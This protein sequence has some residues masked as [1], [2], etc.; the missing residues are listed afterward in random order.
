MRKISIMQPFFFPSLYYFFLIKNADIFV[1]LDNVQFSKQSWQS[2]NRV[3]INHTMNWINLPLE[4]SKSKKNINEIYIN[5][6]QIF[7]IKKFAKKINQ[8]CGLSL[9]GMDNFEYI[10]TSLEKVGWNLS[11]FNILNIENICNLFEIDT[12]F[13][14]SSELILKDTRSERLLDIVKQMGGDVYNATEGAREYMELDGYHL[15]DLNNIQINY[16]KPNKLKF[17]PSEGYASAL[18]YLSRWQNLKLKLQDTGE[19]TND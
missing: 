13:V 18:A 6:A 12:K 2:R 3:E 10:Y 8:S 16:F 1:F 11:E 7:E 9:F 19:Q 17:E 14:R 4:K 15:W 5:K